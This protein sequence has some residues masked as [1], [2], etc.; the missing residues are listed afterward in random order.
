MK[1]MFEEKEKERSRETEERKGEET[2]PT[3]MREW[4]QELKEGNRERR[5]KER[6]EKGEKKRKERKEWREKVRGGGRRGVKRGEST[7]G[8]SLTK[9]RKTN[10]L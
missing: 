7:V 2:V 8:L 10:F 3:P 9:L 1:T 4:E 5:R 6:G